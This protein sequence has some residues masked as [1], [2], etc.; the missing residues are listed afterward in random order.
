[1]ICDHCILEK[2]CNTACLNLIQIVKNKKDQ[3]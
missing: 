1:M 2:C 3:I